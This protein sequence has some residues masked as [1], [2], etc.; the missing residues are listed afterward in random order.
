MC[1]K[2]IENVKKKFYCIIDVKFLKYN[3]T[4][5]PLEQVLQFYE[6]IENGIVVM[7]RKV[8]RSIEISLKGSKILAV[9]FAK[10]LQ[11]KTY[12]HPL[13]YFEYIV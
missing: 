1:R 10:D 6:K 13:A 5:K 12:T 4:L 3:T 11:Y 9:G 8:K 7:R 2:Y